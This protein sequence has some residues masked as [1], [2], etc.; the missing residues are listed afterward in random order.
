MEKENLL[1]WTKEQFDLHKSAKQSAFS[2]KIIPGSQPILGV[3][4]P[5]LRKMAKEIA[6]TDYR[7]FLDNAPD[8]YMEYQ[9]LKAYSLGYAKDDIDTLLE[10]AD[11]FVPQIHD[12]CVNDSFCQNFSIA[13]KESARVY[14]WL[15]KYAA[16][17][18]EYS[19]RVV[20][21]ML[22][23]HFLTDEY[24]DR[25]L[26]LCDVLKNDGYYTKMAVAW[27]VATA[28]AK[29]PEKTGEYLLNNSLDDWTYNKA[30][31]KMRESY[32]VS[33][34]DKEWLRTLRR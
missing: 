22:L 17:D 6:K 1:S 10:C 32:R 15:L 25:V 31:Q 20:A 21:V 9:I 16:K 24:I 11:S 30:L 26:S 33:A 28:Y 3:K 8:T 34:G 12:W 4:L 18:E 19:Q 29:F 5:Q 2:S 27:C 13:R 14:D 7:F 23:S